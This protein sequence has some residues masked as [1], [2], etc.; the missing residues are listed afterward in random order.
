MPPKQSTCRTSS[1]ILK[2]QHEMYDETGHAKNN[3][4]YSDIIN[5]S[6][7][8]NVSV[9]GL[10]VSWSIIVQFLRQTR[11]P[12]RWIYGYILI[13]GLTK[14]NQSKFQGA[15][16]CQGCYEDMQPY[17]LKVVHEMGACSLTA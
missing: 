1:N 13:L 5:I 2:L 12:S 17:L 6:E 16:N 9:V 10:E 4:G 3:K 8:T 7:E 15:W 14:A 11:L